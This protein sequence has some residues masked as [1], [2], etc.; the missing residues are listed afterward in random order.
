MYS[1]S[2]G[3]SKII[4]TEFKK[5]APFTP[6]EESHDI[7]PYDPVLIES[8]AAGQVYAETSNHA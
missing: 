5:M 2:H 1:D 8:L 3:M 4:V 7:F 6:R